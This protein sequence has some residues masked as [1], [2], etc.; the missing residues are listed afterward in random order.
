[1]K[2]GT[3]FTITG[4]DKKSPHSKTVVGMKF[5]AKMV[6]EYNIVAMSMEGRRFIFNKNRIKYDT[7]TQKSKES[8]ASD[9]ILKTP[10]QKKKR[11]RPKGSK[12]K[13]KPGSE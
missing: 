2:P 12:N 11:G 1:M 13:K 10:V 4:L 6:T 9:K 3:R 5:V 7:G 8:P